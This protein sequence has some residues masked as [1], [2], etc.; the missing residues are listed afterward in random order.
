MSASIS[1]G[2]ICSVSSLFAGLLS[3]GHAAP[4]LVN[5]Q[6]SDGTALVG[7]VVFLES[8]QAAQLAK[9]LAGAV[10]AQENKVF[11]PQVLVVT[12]GTAVSFP[13]ND[14]VR[15][16]VYSFSS[17]KKFD[18]KLYSGIPANPVVFDRPGIAVLGCNIHDYMVAW[19]LVVDTPYFAT[20]PA[21]GQVT[22]DVPPGKYTLRAWHPRMPVG[23]EALSQPLD[24]TAAG[25]KVAVKLGSI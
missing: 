7:T 10:M 17:A 20:T 14:S 8:P 22:I 16:H 21:S 23:A 24:V 4:V 19:V 3:A 15:H 1:L 25:G 6:A 5:A 11:V 18:L 9:P 2:R 12:R 13:N